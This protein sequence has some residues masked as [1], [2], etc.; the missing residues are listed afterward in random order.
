MWPHIASTASL[1]GVWMYL[2]TIIFISDKMPAHMSLLFVRVRFVMSLPCDEMAELQELM[3]FEPT[4]PVNSSRVTN[5]PPHD[6]STTKSTA[7]TTVTRSGM[8]HRHCPSLHSG[9]RDGARDGVGAKEQAARDA[10][11]KDFSA[12]RPRVSSS[13]GAP[14]CSLPMRARMSSMMLTSVCAAVL[15]ELPELLESESAASSP[16]GHPPSA[17]EA[18]GGRCWRATSAIQQW[19]TGIAVSSRMGPLPVPIP[20]ESEL[21][22]GA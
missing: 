11:M 4:E 14:A 10:D 15:E 6:S 9:H 12:M 7:A 8:E 5:M 22:A 20:A 1:A 18:A 16:A 21:R 13:D 3:A 17:G 19:G 2:S